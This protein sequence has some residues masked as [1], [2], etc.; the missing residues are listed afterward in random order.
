V[1]I[2]AGLD[3][4]IDRQLRLEDIGRNT[5]HYRTKTAC[6]R[7]SQ[8]RPRSLNGVKLVEALYQQIEA[9]WN[10]SRRPPSSK[11]WVLRQ[12]PLSAASRSPE[13]WL[14]RLIIEFDRID[15]LRWFNQIPV[16]SGLL[17]PRNA[18]RRAIDL[19]H[20][21]DQHSGQR[22]YELV[23]LKVRSDTPLYAAFEILQYG[24]LYLFSRQH[25][26][27]L[28]YG[29]AQQE[30]LAADRIHLRVLAPYKF[31]VG[32]NLGW[33]EGVLTPG[34]HAV[35][36]QL[37]IPVEMDLAFHVLIGV[38]REAAFVGT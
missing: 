12:Q 25:S 16:A 7:L 33:L 17:G 19:V 35:A 37:Q 28:G 24:L 5:S 9:N 32:S 34:L 38:N 14:E 13:T 11:N 29:A 27:E 18:R 26:D 22:C 36:G 6:Q 8:P 20:Q 4:V 1:D 23:E 30:L 15:K 2:L 10:S 21:C 31:Y 3:H